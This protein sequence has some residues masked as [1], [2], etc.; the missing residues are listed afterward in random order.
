M[1]RCWA[2]ALRCGKFVV[3]RIVVSLSFGG[4]RRQCPCSGVCL[5]SF[6]GHFLKTECYSIHIQP[7]KSFLDSD[8]L[9]DIGMRNNLTMAYNETRICSGFQNPLQLSARNGDEMHPCLLKVN[10]R[11]RRDCRKTSPHFTSLSRPVHTTRSNGPWR[12]P[13]E[14]GRSNG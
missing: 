9:H 10:A 4:V 11:M 13:V 2:L 12:R 14:T 8:S 3:Y 5:L 6:I 7:I 1:S